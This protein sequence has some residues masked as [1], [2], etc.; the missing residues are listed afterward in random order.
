MRGSFPRMIASI[1]AAV[2]LCSPVLSRPAGRPANDEESAKDAYR[3]YVLAWK[4]KDVASLRQ[5]IADDYMAVNGQGEVSTKENAIATASTDLVW[6]VM[7]VDEI[8]ARIFGYSAVVSGLISAQ[9]KTSEGKTI[10]PKVRF[11][12]ALIKRKGRWQLAGTQSSP[13]SQAQQKDD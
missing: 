5:L 2:A 4:S 12:A 8:H 7:T 13:V 10:S 3:Q 9:G 6:D 11:L 1:L